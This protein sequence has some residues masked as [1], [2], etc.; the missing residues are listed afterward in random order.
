MLHPLNQAVTIFIDVTAF[1]FDTQF[2][3]HDRRFSG[4]EVRD[5]Q[6]KNFLKLINR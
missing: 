1:L 4:R 6:P 3:T 5:G 2:D